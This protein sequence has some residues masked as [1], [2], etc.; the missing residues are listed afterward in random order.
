MR[1]FKKKTLKSDWE[2]EINKITLNL[3]ILAKI[4]K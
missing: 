2:G 1:I 3:T 4:N